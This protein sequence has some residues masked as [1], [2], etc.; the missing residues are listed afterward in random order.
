M[1]ALVQ[2]PT[3][4]SSA[5]YEAA[6]ANLHMKTPANL[7]VETEIDSGEERRPVA[8]AEAHVHKLRAA[9]SA[10]RGKHSASAQIS[11][12]VVLES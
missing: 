9:R 4:K 1:P 11:D 2:A 3:T 10:S 12:K 8:V 7:H 5:D 6:C